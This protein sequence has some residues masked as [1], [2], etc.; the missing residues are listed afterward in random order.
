MYVPSAGLS[1]A[2]R[3]SSAAPRATLESSSLAPSGTVSPN[4][5][6]MMACRLGMRT[7]PPTISTAAMTSAGLA[8]DTEATADRS[9]AL[10]RASKSAVMLLK[11]LRGTVKF[12][13]P[14]SVR[15]STVTLASGSWESSFLARSQANSSRWPR[16]VPGVTYTCAT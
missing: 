15:F 11:S 8:E 7:P 1:V 6:E 3:V 2:L 5:E 14:L 9:R 13:S 10:K 16:F 12:T 4:I